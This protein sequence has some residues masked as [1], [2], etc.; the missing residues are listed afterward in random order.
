[1]KSIKLSILFFI[2]VF[3]AKVDSNAQ[4]FLG[5]HTTS[6]GGVTNVNYNPAIADNHYKFDMNL[7]S[8]G[9]TVNNNYLGADKNLLFHP[10]TFTE[11]NIKE[12]LNGK[13]KR[14]FIGTQTQGPLSFL[15]SWGKNKSN[16]NAI[17]LTY[18]HNLIV[19]ADNL[20]EIWV[21]TFYHGM[22]KKGNDIINFLGKDFVGQH[23]DV[24]AASW[25]DVGL[26]YSRVVLDKDKHMLK[27]GG[28]L[29]Y[30]LGTHS[31]Y[32]YSNGFDYKF[33]TLDS[34]TITNGS[35]GYGRSG[36]VGQ[37]TFTAD[38]LFQ[39]K[40]SIGLDLG[41]VYEYRPKKEEHTYDMDC[42][43]W[44]KLWQERYKFA[45]G[46]SIIDMGKLNFKDNTVAKD[47]KT[48]DANTIHGDYT[49]YWE[50]V[51][52]KINS[53]ESIDNVVD[54][55]FI[56]NNRK[57]INIWLPTTFNA[58]FDWNIW[59]GFG[60]NA[61]ATITHN[62]AKDRSQV[63]RA[64]IYSLTPKYESKWYG[65]ALPLSID[66]NSHFQA[67]LNIRLGPLFIGSSDMIG[68]LAKKYRYNA[69]IYLGLKVSI[70][71]KKP[72][73]RDKDL[74]SNK[75]DKCKK[76]KGTCESGGCP[77]RDGDGI[78]DIDDKCP[79]EKGTK[80][81]GGC[82]DRDDDKI[83][84]KDDKCPD[85]AGLKE[86]KGCPD[87]DGDG[88]QDSEDDC[89]DVKG[90]KEF[91]GCPDTDGDSIPDPLDKCPTIKGLKEFQ[92]CP[93]R[94]G[95][96]VQDSEDECP[97]AKGSKEFKGC[98][99]TDGD[100][101]PDNVDNC[102]KVAGPISNKG[103]PEIKKEVIEKMKKAAQGTY[104]ETGKDVLK[105]ESFVSLDKVVAA[106]NADN[107]L[108]LDI[109]GHTDNV[110]D[111]ALNLELSNKRAAAVRNYLIKKGIN[112]ARMTSQGFGETKPVGDNNTAL[113]RALNRRVELNL[114]NF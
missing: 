73:D 22:G 32:A 19:N 87:R 90:S 58:Y 48:N 111:D 114:R 30:L 6:F 99:D 21:R 97:D 93:D 75:V 85:V 43:K 66:A 13:D 89:I 51:R 31:V 47:F 110:G 41:A 26:T 18:H 74:M 81:M 12:N 45:V 78:V 108:N 67:G 107:T 88:I 16:K 96:G 95:D 102:P 2:F 106:L 49:T 65:L 35:G 101:L 98:P 83:I 62:L 56:A 14:A 69:D 46:A 113:G 37:G 86:F 91:K 112:P 28:T 55:R 44:Y 27:V 33:N 105:K 94:D 63:H 60:I 103:C 29:K 77:D 61:A 9:F 80:E 72:G 4:H 25:I 15:F 42:K 59:K 34:V 109:E 53:I 104:F 38:Q 17:A 68:M 100:G 84:D 24:K 7:I 10:K 64:S 20:N 8:F 82:P 39:T 70:P 5:M 54:T 36:Y 79:D 57:A 23:V 1:M 50:L 3:F 71:Y 40:G 11:S 92:G 52:T 76:E